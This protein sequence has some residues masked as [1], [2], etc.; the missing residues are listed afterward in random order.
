MVEVVLGGGGLVVVVL[1]EVLVEEVEEVDDEVDEEGVELPEPLAP[2][3]AARTPDP[4]SVVLVVED[5]ED[6][7]VD[8]DPDVL[9]VVELEGAAPASA[10]L[11]GW[12]EPA[13]LMVGSG[14]TGGRFS[15]ARRASSCW[16]FASR[17][18]SRRSRAGSSAG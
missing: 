5:D 11:A 9:L 10:R 4:P 12:A 15:L 8:P 6:V 3:A 13:G 18:L 7:V 14:C 1:V 2:V 17:A 16:I